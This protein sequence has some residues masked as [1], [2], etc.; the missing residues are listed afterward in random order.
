MRVQ[1]PHC[2]AKLNLDEE[3]FADGRRS[4]V[5]CWMCTLPVELSSSP[6]K[7]GPPTIAVSS[8]APHERCR[9]SRLEGV[10]NSQTADLALPRDKTIKISII[11]GSSQGMEYDLSRPL[12]TIGRLGG[13]VAEQAIVDTG[14]EF[15]IRRLGGRTKMCIPS[16]EENSVIQRR[17][18][19][20]HKEIGQ[21]GL[22]RVRWQCVVVSF[23]LLS[24]GPACARAQGQTTS[25]AAG[26]TRQEQPA[27]P[28]QQEDQG[29]KPSLITPLQPRTETEPYTPITARQRLRWLITNTIGPPHLAGGVVTSAFGT[30][31]DRPREYG[32]G[33]PG[34]GERFGIRLSGV[35]TS[36]IMEASAGALW[37]EDPRYFRVP[38]ESF[39]ARLRN[40]TKQTFL[41]RRRNGNFAPAYARFA[42]IPG[43]NF[44]SNA[45][46]PD[47]EANNH[48]AVLRTL[49]GFAGRM[50]ANAFD[51]FWPD[52]K[53]HLFHR[54]H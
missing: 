28:D 9:D 32:P 48:E 29:S 52:V 17:Y 24:V 31:L 46:R 2:G 13:D 40:V 35:S 10:R 1:C 49:E 21:M 7:P 33:W 18:V 25:P 38:E 27:N 53:T 43:N 8:S 11:A 44:L 6:I 39:G 37:G 12:M 30:A 41:A 3:R 26:T 14:E 20:V 16:R 34:F 50:S 47:S 15:G 4:Q 22:V 42:A 5:T 23:A 45:W 54:S 51:E 36:N 19:L